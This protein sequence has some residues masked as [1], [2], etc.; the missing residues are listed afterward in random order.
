MT[1]LMAD[2]PIFTRVDKVY[3]LEEGYKMKM[4]EY[5]DDKGRDKG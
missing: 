5:E 2:L 4:D 3:R 1:L